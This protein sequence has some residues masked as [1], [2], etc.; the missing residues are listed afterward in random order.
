MVAIATEGPSNSSRRRLLGIDTRKS[1]AS[2][3]VPVFAQTALRFKSIGAVRICIFR[4]FQQFSR[5]SGSFVLGEH[6][7]TCAFEIDRSSK[8]TTKM[9]TENRKSYEN[10]EL[11][12]KSRLDRQ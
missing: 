2:D 6:S 12:P 8:F 1:G 5:V 9:K 10:R 3:Y 11:R 4:S 7:E